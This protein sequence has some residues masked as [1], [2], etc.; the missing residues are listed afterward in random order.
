MEGWILIV[1]MIIQSLDMT[2]FVSIRASGL[3]ARSGLIWESKARGSKPNAQVCFVPGA[4]L[5]FTSSRRKK[6]CAGAAV[7]VATKAKG[8]RPE[9]Q[10]LRLDAQAHCPK[11]KAQGPTCIAH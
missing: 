6:P 5:C 7:S 4:E 9:V 8:P 3:I 1:V 2:H 10:G 11:S